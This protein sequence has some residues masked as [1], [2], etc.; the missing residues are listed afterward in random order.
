MSG[1][2]SRITS[3]SG[4]TDFDLNVNGI[5]ANFAPAQ[6]GG[7]ARLHN[8]VATIPGVKQRLLL[9][10]DAHFTGTAVVLSGITAR[11][12]RLPLEVKGS[13]SA[14]VNCQS[15]AL[16]SMQF[17][18]HADAFSTT[19]LAS[20][21][22]LDQKNW[23]LPFLS[24]PADKLP[25]FRASGT[26]SIEALELGRLGIENFTAHLE[27]A[28]R[29]LLISRLNNRVAGGSIQ[30]DWR[31][32][33][34]ASP[35]RYS[36]SGILTAIAPDRVGLPTLAAWVSGKTNMKYSVN[37][38]GLSGTDM[39]GSATGKA[40]FLVANGTSQAVA[41]EPS[42]PLHFQSLQGACELNRQ[43]LSFTQSKVKAEDRIYDLSGSVS[44]ADKQ[45]KLKIGNSANQWEITG[46]L[47]NPNVVAQR[48]TAQEA[49]SH[50]Q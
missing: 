10:S 37:F 3:I 29:T 8:V 2:R 18:L 42:K 30:G 35:V 44:F 6:P 49:A 36:G 14:P 17:D 26:L 19:E 43:I 15:G 38:S 27:V 39:L 20:L 34:S 21:L 13:V 7:T 40:E 46:A 41:L 22:G 47:D 48:P 24:S 5:W 32:D 9:S 33:W 25:D 1:F 11:F 4:S 45:A 28:D 16:C 12:E 50:V 31:V 23:R